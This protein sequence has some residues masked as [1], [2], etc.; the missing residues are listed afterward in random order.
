M[1][2]EKPLIYDLY[3]DEGPVLLIRG[4]DPR[5]ILDVAT[6]H[7]RGEG[8][9]VTDTLADIRVSNVRAV[10]CNPE[11]HEGE[12]GWCDG[13]MTVHYMPERGGRGSFPGAFVNV[14]YRMVLAKGFIGSAVNAALA[15]DCGHATP[16]RCAERRCRT[17]QVAP[18]IASKL[19]DNFRNDRWTVN[20]A[21]AA[22]MDTFDDLE[23]NYTI[24]PLHTARITM[25]VNAELPEYLRLAVVDEN[26]RIVVADAKR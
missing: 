13:S 20:A 24:G 25:L 14:S 26:D 4:D 21:D 22:V 16:E 8:L 15:K 1:P 17:P 2:K 11:G 18:G 9:V 10:P 23:S 3:N 5:M 12:L 7:A 19:I 6:K